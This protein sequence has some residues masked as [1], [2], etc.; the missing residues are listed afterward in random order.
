MKGK[1]KS[2][3][4]RTPGV[5]SVERKTDALRNDLAKM[6]SS[7]SEHSEAIEQ[8]KA[9]PDQINLIL[10]MLSKAPNTT[11]QVDDDKEKDD[12]ITALLGKSVEGI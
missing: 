10:S 5:T 4:K 2:K 6:A 3:V 12:P 7:I 1:S 11:E 8:L 9:V